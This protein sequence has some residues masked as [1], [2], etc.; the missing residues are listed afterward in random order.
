MISDSFAL[1][2]KPRRPWLDLEEL[3]ATFHRL[4]AVAHPD[5]TGD[6]AASAGLNAAYA[7]LRDPGS[8]LRHLLELE[9]PATLAQTRDV[10][11]ALGEI[12]VQLA[13]LRRAVDAFV[14]Q[15]STASTPLSQ[16][17]LASERFTLEH[18]V[19]KEIAA[20]E[21]VNGRA[22]E[23]LVQLDAYWP[24]RAA[25]TYE[26]VAALQQE[27]SYYGKWSWHLREALFRLQTGTSES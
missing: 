2:E 1:L 23:L 22:L 21:T 25:E 13:T 26:H 9:H 24:E 16:A 5:R 6:S 12:F 20:L 4:T 14:E 19:E 18:D 7:L 11:P 10:P 17:L 27:L 8:R 3:K 15:R